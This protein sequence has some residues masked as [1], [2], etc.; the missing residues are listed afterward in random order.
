MESF[1][2]NPAAD[3]AH[4]RSVLDRH[5]RFLSLSGLSGIAAGLTAFMGVFLAVSYL[6]A[7]GLLLPGW[8]GLPAPQ[9]AHAPDHLWV[10]GGIALGTL[11]V[12][13]G[14]AW[15]FS[16]RLARK[17]GDT[18]SWN[19]TSKRLAAQLFLPVSVGAV[20]C[21][22]LVYHG[23]LALLAPISLVFYGLGLFGASKY[24]L[25]EVRYLGLSECV[26]GL[27]GL[28]FPGTGLLVWAL[29][30]GLLHIG[31]GLYMYNRYERSAQ[32]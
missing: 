27:I 18:P 32:V 29:G 10:L 6:E 13:L 2:P 3:L 25:H 5:T 23:L 1:P 17:R 22:L 11:L 12:A 30:F 24:T 31:Y 8:S 4:I 9:L 16:A 20:V 26:L 28:A 14:L 7:N 19:R 15:H 21:L